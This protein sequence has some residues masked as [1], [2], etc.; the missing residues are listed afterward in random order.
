MSFTDYSQ[1]LAI[2]DSWSDEKLDATIQKYKTE[3]KRANEE[4][5]NAHKRYT[6]LSRN[7]E[8]LERMKGYRDAKKLKKEFTLKKEHLKLLARMEFKNYEYSDHV[9]LGVEGKKPFGNSNIEAD[10]A[11]IL[12]LEINEDGEF[13]DETEKEVDKLLAELPLAVHHL[14]QTAL[15]NFE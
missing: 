12:E 2:T 10:I 9:F 8:G 7:V 11:G 3:F 15:E 5:N 14:I 6:F 4:N 13:D 1:M